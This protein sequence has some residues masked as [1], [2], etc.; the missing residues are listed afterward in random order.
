MHSLYFS[1]E[2]SIPHSQQNAKWWC[3]ARIY[4]PEDRLF[5]AHLGGFRAE[6]YG[7]TDSF[8]PKGWPTDVSRT[9]IEEEALTVDDEASGLDL[10]NTTTCERAQESVKSGA[11]QFINNGYAITHPDFYLKSWASLDELVS[12]AA[13]YKTSGGGN[14]MPTLDAVLQMM[15]AL[16]KSGESVRAVYWFG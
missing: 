4:F 16:T 2:S 7:I 14:A 1:I 11:S 5:W 8:P 12:V 10:P 9:T 3:V 6:D 15:H 13:R